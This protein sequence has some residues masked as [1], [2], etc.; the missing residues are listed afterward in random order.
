MSS[1]D[2]SSSECGSA[3][4]VSSCKSQFVGALIKQLSAAGHR[5]LIFSQSRIM[6]D[7]LGMQLN[8]MELR[9]LRIDGS[10]SGGQREVRQA[11]LH[12]LRQSVVKGRLSK[13]FSATTV[14]DLELTV[15]RTVH[16]PV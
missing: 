14:R 7:I 12:M 1:I 2:R 3:G 15:P 4:A 6:L 5:T 10:L 8:K 16:T 13:D 9:F 11:P